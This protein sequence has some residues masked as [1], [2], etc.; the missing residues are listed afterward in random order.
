MPASHVGVEALQSMFLL[1]GSDLF[2]EMEVFASLSEVARD[3]VQLD[4]THERQLAGNE[5]LERLAVLNLIRLEDA[6]NG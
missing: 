2:R 6:T 3:L 1:E 5:C 4:F